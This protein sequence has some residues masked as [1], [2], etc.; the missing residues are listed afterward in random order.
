[1]IVHDVNPHAADPEKT[2]SLMAHETMG[3]FDTSRRTSLLHSTTTAMTTI[4][5]H[6]TRKSGSMTP[7]PVREIQA[8]L[9]RE[10]DLQNMQELQIAEA[11]I[12]E[13]QKAESDALDDCDLRS[14]PSVELCSTTEMLEVFSEFYDGDKQDMR[15][16]F[17]DDTRIDSSVPFSAREF[18]LDFTGS[19]EQVEFPN[20]DF[21]VSTDIDA[22][23][24]NEL[25]R[26]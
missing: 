17:V 10:E 19:A 13:A 25:L 3:F 4:K 18:D 1:M 16:Q 15:G 8:I 11:V 12:Q 20:M 9:Q 21:G 6:H 23:D 2:F 7:K 5:M 24:L 26:G 22:Y 14:A